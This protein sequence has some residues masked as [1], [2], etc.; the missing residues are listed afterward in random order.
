MKLSVFLVLLPSVSAFVPSAHPASSQ[1]ASTGQEHG[2]A[3]S[4]A[5]LTAQQESSNEDAGLWSVASMWKGVVGSASDTKAKVDSTV[6]DSA[7]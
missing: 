4:I 6:R 7:G 3:S 2:T 5:P 1:L